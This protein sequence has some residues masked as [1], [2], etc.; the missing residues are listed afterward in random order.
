MSYDRKLEQLCTHEVVEE[1]LY[2][3]TDRQTLVPLRPIASATTVKVRY[4]R[5]QEVPSIGCHLPAVVKG[6]SQGPFTITL[7]V[8]DTLY[9]SVDDRPT[10]A[11][12]ITPGVGLSIN[13]VVKELNS[14][15]SNV[16]FSS[17]KLGQLQATSRSLGKGSKIQVVDNQTSTY[18][19]LPTK[20][21]LGQTTIPGWSL[22]NDP[23]A[24]SD[25][26]TRLVVFD[27]R[28]EGSND[29]FEI[30]Y[31][32]IREECRRCHGT[33]VEHD[34]VF[35]NKGA[36][37]IAKDYDLLVQ[38]TLKI[39]YTEKGSNQFHLW[40]GTGIVNAI[41]QKNTASLQNIITNDIREAFK[42]WQNI[43][44]QQE[45]VVGQEV[46]DEEFPSMLLLVDLTKDEKD[47][48]LIYVNALVR[49]RSSKPVQISRALKLPL[50]YD[51][52]GSSVQD[53]LFKIEKA[54]GQ[55]SFR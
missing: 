34:W 22:V 37:V 49:S 11:L 26:P 44:K 16:Q 3:G 7:G 33:G 51:I 38:E 32:T 46:S 52:M 36:V 54:K 10:Q 21:F 17:S 9:L 27:T 50:P 6:S 53:T 15:T 42:N 48:T 47:P 39:L 35:D 30:N 14:Q 2:L 8:N 13:K 55:Q 4:S 43:K 20:V 41:G 1:A 28:I 23:N 40:Y 45:E 29:F 24:L 12:K 19:G 31:S 5:L 25:R 18:F